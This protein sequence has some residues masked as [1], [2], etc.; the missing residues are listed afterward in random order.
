MVI[1]MRA[2]STDERRMVPDWMHL[3]LSLFVDGKIVA[4]VVQMPVIEHFEN[5]VHFHDYSGDPDGSILIILYSVVYNQ[6][7]FLALI[8]VVVYLELVILPSFE[9][10]SDPRIP[11]CQIYDSVTDAVDIDV[12]CEQ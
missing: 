10:V 11:S 12:V 3:D 4:G 1:I 7:Q 5:V 9:K 8:A 6:E 2:M